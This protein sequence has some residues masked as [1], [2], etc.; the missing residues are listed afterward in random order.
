M[1]G[2]RER[3]L[4]IRDAIGRIRSRMPADYEAFA[5]DELVQV[6]ALYHL[7]IIGEAVRALSEPLKEKHAEVPWRKIVGMRNVL[8]H[9]YFQ[10]EIELVWAVLEQDLSSLDETVKA[11]LEEV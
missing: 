4:D 9:T 1:R 10:T 2:D 6:W 11:M 8:I 7:Q 3:L 5:E